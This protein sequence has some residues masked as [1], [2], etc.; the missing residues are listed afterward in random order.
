M[1]DFKR[2]D[3]YS[4]Y[5][6]DGWDFFYEEDDN[7][8]DEA[9][10]DIDNLDVPSLDDQ[11]G[12]E[13]NSSEKGGGSSEPEDIL[14]KLRERDGPKYYSGANV[15]DHLDQSMLRKAEQEKEEREAEE[16]RALLQEE[17][18][19][20]K[21][22][23]KKAKKKSGYVSES[24]RE[25]RQNPPPRSEPGRASDRPKQEHSFA[26][27]IDRVNVAER[28][29]DENRRHIA[30]LHADG[31][32]MK[33][34]E[35]ESRLHREAAQAEQSGRSVSRKESEPRSGQESRKT[36]RADVIRERAEHL[37]QETLHTRDTRQRE[38][39]NID[40]VSAAERILDQSQ[41]H[42]ANLHADEKRMKTAQAEENRAGKNPSDR[43]NESVR[44]GRKHTD[45]LDRSTSHPDVSSNRSRETP[46]GSPGRADRYS[47]KPAET[48]VQD[49]QTGRRQSQ[50][51]RTGESQSQKEAR[52]DRIREDAQ[53]R[54]NQETIR[55][56]GADKPERK[57][58]GPS[59]DNGQPSTS[60]HAQRP[61][62]PEP[63][64]GI[65]GQKPDQQQ[66]GSF[67]EKRN[68][69]GKAPSPA[70]DRS[71][72]TGSSKSGS[73][74][75]FKT[76]T[77]AGNA[78]AAGIASAIR[79]AKEA[80][81]AA[82][83]GAG[84]RDDQQNI[85]SAR[86]DLHIPDLR[87]KAQQNSSAPSFA[88]T[89]AEPAGKSG[90]GKS[91][92]VR[93]STQTSFAQSRRQAGKE[94]AGPN[95]AVSESV[96]SQKKGPVQT[97]KP[98]TNGIQA[99]DLKG[100]VQ[101]SE[102]PVF[103]KTGAQTPAAGQ[104]GQPEGFSSRSSLKGFNERSGGSERISGQKQ[105]TVQKASVFS[106]KT[107]ADDSRNRPGSSVL[108]SG[109]QAEDLRE[110][111]A[112]SQ[113]QPQFAKTG[114]GKEPSAKLQ[115]E[116]ASKATVQ[117]AVTGTKLKESLKAGGEFKAGVEAEDLRQ[118]AA[119][120]Q[121]VSGFART[122]VSAEETA[123]LQSEKAGRASVRKSILPGAKK[124]KPV[125]GDL[126]AGVQAEDLK[127][128]AK[129]NPFRQN[130]AK[131]SIRTDK[132][133][134][135]PSA[136]PHKALIK[137]AIPGKQKPGT[138]S[139]AGM[140]TET[141]N[142]ALN[143]TGRLS[144]AEKSGLKTSAEKSVHADKAAAS[145]QKA[146][147]GNAAL[148]QMQDGLKNK[149]GLKTSEKPGKTVSAVPEKALHQSNR[150]GSEKNADLADKHASSKKNLKEQTDFKTGVAH[151]DLKAK[152]ERLQKEAE[153]KA[154]KTAA[155]KET[156][157]EAGKTEKTKSALIKN[158]SAIKAG[159]KGKAGETVPD[160]TNHAGSETG[161]KE[162]AAG[163]DAGASKAGAK[164]GKDV[165]T[166]SGKEVE[167]IDAKARSLDQAAI[168]AKAKT[169]KKTIQTAVTEEA[170]G[171]TAEKAI[172]K[173]AMKTRAAAA[174]QKIAFRRPDGTIE[175]KEVQIA[176]A[177][178][179]EE[180]GKAAEAVSGKEETGLLSGKGK[181]SAK[182]VPALAGIRT[183]AETQTTI[184]LDDM[185]DEELKAFADSLSEEDKAELISQLDLSQDGE[186]ES[187]IKTAAPK[188]FEKTRSVLKSGWKFAVG[189]G[190]VLMVGGHYLILGARTY[191]RLTRY[192]KRA[193]SQSSILEDGG[194]HVYL[195]SAQR[196]AAAPVKKITHK[197][198]NRYVRRPV[199]RAVNRYLVQ[200]VKKAT[201]KAAVTTA[202]KVGSFAS[203]VA[204]KTV[205]LIIKGLSALFSSNPVMMIIVVIIT[206]ILGICFL[207]AKYEMDNVESGM[208]CYGDSASYSADYSHN[209]T[210]GDE[211]NLRNRE[212]I[213]QYLMNEMG[214]SLEQTC[215]V[216]GNLWQES[217]FESDALETGG[218]GHGIVQWSFERVTSLQNFASAHGKPWTDLGIQLAFLNHEVN[219]LG[220]KRELQNFGFFAAGQS[221]AYYAEAWC[222]G[223]ERPLVMEPVRKQK[224]Q[225]IYSTMSTREENRDRIKEHKRRLDEEDY[226]D[227]YVPED[228]YYYESDT[229][230]ASTCTPAAASLLG[231]SSYT[232]GN[233]TG[234]IDSD[235][236]FESP[237]YQD[238]GVNGV[239]GLVGGQSTQL[240]GQ[241]TWFAAGRFY[242]VYGYTC[243]GHGNG[244]DVARNLAAADNNFDWVTTDYNRVKGGS[245]GSWFDG[246]YGHVYFVK[247][248]HPDEQ[249]MVIEEGN[250]SDGVTM[251]QQGFPTWADAMAH[252]NRRQVS[253]AYLMSMSSN[254][255]VPRT[256]PSSAYSSGAG[257]NPGDAM[258]M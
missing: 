206:C 192:L 98:F 7:Q 47:Q 139:A 10:K 89:G 95:S 208:M 163:K 251:M 179:A 204:K 229:Y 93:N 119:K 172:L 85:P 174:T 117:K 31:N 236:K 70:A 43:L 243:P 94:S 175:V 104:K 69:S 142:G 216:L 27:K 12:N 210:G 237:A 151:D 91:E 167:T 26:S 105:A 87:R 160:N 2:S 116:K 169:V 231:G 200:P 88:K 184:N 177:K 15:E 212:I 152:A 242:E 109:V 92:A 209:A 36:E 79:A 136:K 254:F 203:E 82:E 201:K 215:G 198:V 8:E 214:F 146:I 126:K 149:G 182:A 147:I 6:L 249:Y 164:A 76:A 207:L 29:L 64:S 156:L 24:R 245:I 130:T 16:K 235:P 33:T 205:D 46:S 100:K 107:A 190:H 120:N 226:D 38:N 193:T 129:L 41:R 56:R 28:A 68:A 162:E 3:E 176:S 34:S 30:D 114:A 57:G 137:N 123:K 127:E 61:K 80:E 233:G 141:E 66:S 217:R 67:R 202:K 83:R 188:P 11:P 37:Q 133:E 134:N 53:K 115:T 158:P 110:K 52:S 170:E 20:E 51:Q 258:A 128:K 166:V 97:G 227:G 74:Q 228:D 71:M 4:A 58:A 63:S 42:I 197:V 225:E 218:T 125:L 1:A 103:T 60:F 72:E 99:E 241:C 81:A 247:E 132:T 186:A 112:R 154:A 222:M 59:R 240:L 96:I 183:L 221:P 224:A 49:R 140:Q 62:P 171:D 9:V 84:L 124:E 248:N 257:S 77:G 35:P 150:P 13:K 73:G 148:K 253:Y 219:N 191:K 48:P 135:T 102:R 145:V 185:S 238:P 75:P 195:K 250:F 161:I 23:R 22:G 19:K 17:E 113:S 187:L 256:V 111:A 90:T 118:K 178:G 122:G 244:Q 78:A 18:P 194:A 159:I 144:Q 255:A 157:T 246:I 21:G 181:A 143:Q 106:G 180:A 173:P 50:R 138:L 252:T 5:E 165:L 55:T 131:T 108:Q 153:I 14:E 223:V 121:K 230:I 155:G 25:E 232:M 39:R 234:K 189:T 196:I 45:D 213:K 211:G 44:P 239:G 65:A 40:K 199:K 86:P 168:E 54:Q 32:Q 220:Y 101:Q